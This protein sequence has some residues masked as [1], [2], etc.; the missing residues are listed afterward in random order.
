MKEEHSYLLPVTV[1]LPPPLSTAEYSYME[2]TGLKS[3]CVSF[4]PSATL[5]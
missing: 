5:I 2:N 4:V 1:S 3:R